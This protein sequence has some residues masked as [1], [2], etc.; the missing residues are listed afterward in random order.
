M[1]SQC[2]TF[3][4]CGFNFSGSVTAQMDNVEEILRQVKKALYLF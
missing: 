4:W 2:F 3:P 1:E